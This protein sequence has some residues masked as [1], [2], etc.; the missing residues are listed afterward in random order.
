MNHFFKSKYACVGSE[1]EKKVGRAS[2]FNERSRLERAQIRALPG[3]KWKKS[4]SWIQSTM[5]GS[6]STLSL[7]NSSSLY[8]SRPSESTKAYSSSDKRFSF[9]CFSSKKKQLG[10]MDQILDYIE[11]L[12]AFTLSFRFR[13]SLAAHDELWSFSWFP[14]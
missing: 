2:R 9:T 8:I 10:F 13:I 5:A 6:A 1:K 3:G 4:N 14:S 7:F 11:G 12:S